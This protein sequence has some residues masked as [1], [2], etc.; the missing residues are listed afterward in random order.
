MSDNP[1]VRYAYSSEREA[2]EGFLD[3]QR[4]GLILT[5]EGLDDAAARTAPS[6][7][8]LSLLGLIKHAATWE[9]RWFQVIVAGR[10][11]PENWPAVK[12]EPRD[13]D[14]MVDESDTVDHW[15]AYY[16]EQIEESRAIVASTDLDSPCA[17]KDIIE[18]NV[19]YVLFHMIEETARHGGHADIIRETIDGT[20]QS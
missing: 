14:M 9:R 8:S 13:A 12:T 11:L 15:V 20:R 16:R 7:S 3:Y 5:L 18:C 19:R 2:L 10:E 17:R 1:N 6:A 4:E